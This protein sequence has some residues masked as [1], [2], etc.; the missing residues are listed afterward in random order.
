[1]KTYFVKTQSAVNEMLLH[2]KSCFLNEQFT[3]AS[4]EEAKR[5]FDE[6]V[7]ALEAEYVK[8]SELGYQPSDHESDHA[9][10]CTLGAIDED[11]EVEFLEDSCRY[12]DRGMLE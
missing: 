9:V 3:S 10:Y 1:M 6:E 4:Y 11:G 8:D 2:C 5:I 12:Y 7:E